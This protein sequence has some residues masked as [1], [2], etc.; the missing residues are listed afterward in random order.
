MEE[1]CKD[2]DNYRGS[3]AYGVLFRI[4]VLKEDYFENF[5]ICKNCLVKRLNSDQIYDIKAIIL[6][7]DPHTPRVIK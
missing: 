2:C 4:Y 3:N 7:I 6:E 5:L 1:K